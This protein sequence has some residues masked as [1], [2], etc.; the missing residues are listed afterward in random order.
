MIFKALGSHLVSVLDVE[1]AEIMRHIEQEVRDQDV[2]SKKFRYAMQFMDVSFLSECKFNI[3]ATDVFNNNALINNYLSACGKVMREFEFGSSNNSEEKC[4]PAET[5]VHAIRGFLA[6]LKL[7]KQYDRSCFMQNSG[8]I[9]KCYSAFK[10]MEDKLSQ[11]A[12][13]LPGRQYP[14]A[15]KFETV[16][17]EARVAARSLE[18]EIF[19]LKSKLKSSYLSSTDSSQS[20]EIASPWIEYSKHRS[21]EEGSLAGR[22]LN[23]SSPD[24]V[25]LLSR[26]ST[27]TSPDAG[28]LFMPNGVFSNFPSSTSVFWNSRHDQSSARASGPDQPVFYEQ[29]FRSYHPRESQRGF[30]FEYS[31][32]SVSSISARRF[33]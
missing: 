10:S 5:T 15:S 12:F 14:K 29:A 23:C 11:N 13:R 2:F 24:A 25:P 6:W 33:F 19:S 16:Y 18:Y 20:T 7:S 32:A 3:F 17:D 1:G 30:P 27:Y 8:E 22:N 4:P 31:S 21:H 28:S 9:W 26:N